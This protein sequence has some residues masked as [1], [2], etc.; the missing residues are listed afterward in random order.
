[1][2]EDVDPAKFQQHPFW[3]NP[4]GSGPYKVKEVKMNDYLIMVP[5]ENFHEGVA[6]IDEIVAYP[7]KD[8]D[9]NLVKN[10]LAGSLDYGFTK[11]V[12]DVKALEEMDHMRV[13]PAD[14]PYTRMVW[15]NKYAKN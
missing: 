9:A 2:L 10:A 3:Q 5:F 11:N 12:A 1:Y 13:I 8:N 15:F 4:V 7:S 14:I 6:R